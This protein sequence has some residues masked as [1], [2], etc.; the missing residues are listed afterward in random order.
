MIQLWHTDWDVQ[1]A[2]H[3]S[4]GVIVCVVRQLMHEVCMVWFT[5]EVHPNSSNTAG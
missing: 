1:H 3:M 4:V 5:V 2:T